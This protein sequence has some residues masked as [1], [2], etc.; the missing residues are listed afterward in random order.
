MTVL[1]AILAAAIAFAVTTASLAEDHPEG[2]HIHDAYART[3]GGLGSSGAVFLMMHNNTATDDR[4]IEVR[5]DVAERAELHGHSEDANGV[6]SM[7][8]IEGGIPLPAGEMHALARGGDH[9]MLMGLTR[10]LRDGDTITLTLVFEVA[11][12]VTLEVP[13]D[14][15]R[16]PGQGMDHSG[17]DMPKLTE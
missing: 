16:K 1:R 13:V 11:G 10:D 15:A 14:N 9:V 12:E 5:S 2:L 4:L 3:S 8:R 17:H 6:M 7:G